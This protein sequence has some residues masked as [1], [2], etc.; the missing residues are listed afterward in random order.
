MDDLVATGGARADD[1]CHEEAVDE[2]PLPVDPSEIGAVEIGRETRFEGASGILIDPHS[3]QM[4]PDRQ[5]FIVQVAQQAVE[6]G[7]P[8]VEVADI[9]GLKG[10]ALQLKGQHDVAGI[11]RHHVLVQMP[12][13]GQEFGGVG[14]A[15]RNLE[16]HRICWRRAA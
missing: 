14:L 5:P 9:G 12:R 6:L 13:V 15:L 16:W 11:E 8:V 7:V 3:D 10:A 4:R 2:H 1:Q